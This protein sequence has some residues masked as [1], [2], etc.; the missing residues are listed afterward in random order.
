[1]AKRNL[2]LLAGAALSAL[3]LA[4]C[5]TPGSNSS[6]N[7]DA[8]GAKTERQVVVVSWGGAYQDA[9]RKAHFE[10]F[11]KATGI[12]IIEQQPTDYGKLQAMLKNNNMEW[13]V[14]QVDGDV[15]PRGIKEGWF[16]KLDWSKIGKQE[17]FIPGTV[18]DFNVGNIQYSYIIAWNTKKWPA[19]KG[20]QTWADVF[21]T[22]KFPGTR[23]LWKYAPGT[24]EAALLADGVAP[25]K[26]YPLDV[27]R[28]LKKLD[29]IKNDIVW[30]DAGGKGAQLLNDG[31]VDIAALWS[32]RA[33][34]AKLKGG[35]VGYTFNQGV[36]LTDSWIIPKGAK[37]VAEALEFIK[38]TA[39][40]KQQAELTKYIAYGWTHKDTGSLVDA[41]ILKELP[42]T[43]DNA[44]VGVVENY[45]WWGQNFDK[46][47][48]K[49]QAWLLK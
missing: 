43:P 29:T 23:S 38:F 41:Q 12:K 49:F 30:W 16:E 9:Q 35:P 6:T 15:V 25:D 14:V 24:I 10:A 45:D 4:A 47:N 39:T 32:G 37:H 8:G 3:V 5:G 36:L 7:K 42:S 1:M 2:R 22:K 44:K 34:D 33:Y 40:P 18:G 46:V 19:D 20:P 27:D 31:E 26:L 17:E 28:A 13:D 11:T 21:D 48:E